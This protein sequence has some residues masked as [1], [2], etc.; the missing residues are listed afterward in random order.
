MVLV[1][2]LAGGGTV[3]GKLYGD[4]GE[5]PSEVVRTGLTDPGAIVQRL[6]DNDALGYAWEMAAPFGLV[7]FGAPAVVAVGLPQAMVNLLSTAPFTFDTRYHYQAVPV[8]ALALGMVETLGWA[9]R[10]WP[11][12]RVGT[13]CGPAVMWALLALAV[14]GATATTV[15]RGPS[16]I[17]RSYG[18]GYWP[19]EPAPGQ[20]VIEQALARLGPDDGVAAHWS[21]TPHVSQRRYAYTF[22]N[23]W[24]NLNYGI[25]P[26]ARGEPA[27]VRW[28]VIQ[29]YDLK[30]EHRALLDELVAG[31]EFVVRTE[32][33]GILVAERVREPAG[34]TGGSRRTR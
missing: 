11:A 15:A 4:L 20:E 19:S 32:D 13:R 28:I 25:D 30:P 31:G 12:V 21:I 26:S 6:A 1:P 24:R 3:Y 22:P 2:H 14:V 33:L 18:L 8:M 9:R 23:P 10:R 17:G 7:P 27:Q 34:F 16:P 5:T 29:T